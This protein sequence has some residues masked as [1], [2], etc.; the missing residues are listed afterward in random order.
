MIDVCDDSVCTYP[1][2]N[3]FPAWLVAKHIEYVKMLLI[4]VLVATSDSVLAHTLY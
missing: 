2:N 4:P 3:T 1:H